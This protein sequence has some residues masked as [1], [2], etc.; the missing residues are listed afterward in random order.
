ML[1]LREWLR[2]LWGTLRP[3]PIDDDL[4]QEIR[5]HLELAEEDARRRG[6][7]PEAA[8]RSARLRVGRPAQAMEQIR[9]QRGLPWLDDLRRD[10][11]HGLRALRHS[12]SFTAIAVMTLALGIGANTAIF[13]IV[14]T[15][16]LRPL[17]YPQPEQLM[18]L[19]TRFP[20]LGFD[21][22]SLSPPEYFEFQELNRSFSAVGA[23]VTAGVNLSADGRAVRVR[24]AFVD[25]PLLR[26]LGVQAAHGRLF[27]PGETQAT[28]S[29]SDSSPRA[30]PRIAILSHDFWQGLLG[31][32]SILGETIEVDGVPHEVLGIMQP[33]AD[34][35]DSGAQVWLP[36][37]LRPANRK[38]RGNHGIYLIGRLEDG[39]SPQAAQTELNA[40][41]ANWG[42]R[43]GLG[44]EK[45]VF[46]LGPAGS[47]DPGALQGHALQMKPLQEEI[48]GS[49]GR[50]VW[51][52]QAAVGL[53][54]LIACAN[55]ASLLL[56]RAE[57]RRRELA[58]RTAIGAS[59]GRLIRQFIAEGLLLSLGGALLGLVV[60][61]AGVLLLLRAYPAALPRMNEIAIDGAALLFTCS[62]AVLTGLLFGLAPLMYTR[63]K[64]LMTGLKE[65]GARGAIGSARQHV[66]RGL[67]VVEIALAVM[68]LTGAGLMVR[69]VYNLTNVDAGFDRTRLMT[70]SLTLPYA[71][72]PDASGRRQLYQR[73]LDSFRAL[74]GVQA[75]TAMSG[76]PP[77][78]SPN[79]TDT[80]IDNYEAP[81]EGPFENVDYYQY[82][83]SDYFETSGIAL[84]Q[85]R[86]FETADAA[87]SGMVAIVNETMARTFWSDE[88]PIGQRLKPCCNMPWFTIIGVAKDVK[89]RGVSQEPGTEV[90]FFVDQTANLDPSIARSPQTINFLLG[91]T[92]PPAALSDTVHR[93]VRQ[94][95]STVPVVR[96]RDMD[97]VFAE[98][99]RRPRLLAQ[100]LG[101]FAGLALL[102]AAIG[103]YGIL[104]YMVAERRREIGIRMALG[105]A[106]SSV[107]A[108]I[109]R[110]GLALTSVG[111]MAGLL[112]ALALSRL[113]G[114]LLFEVQPTDAVTLAA[115]IGTIAVVA[116][117]TCSLPAWRAARLD[118]NTVL[119]ED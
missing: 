23:Y 83:M 48:L 116:A 100:L 73:L 43:A 68:L 52:L 45:H 16:I 51:V 93:I 84:V 27:A 30:V 10:M 6:A 36:L 104:S 88:N 74:P 33:G 53:V 99:I 78:R 13:S 37:G 118:P 72:Y 119:R 87:S 63:V 35:M 101:G 26:A 65:G 15:V 77:E 31:G 14:S 85:G 105:A 61:Q 56:A 12:P 25:E 62:V 91:T 106:R 32:R 95:D 103:A 39:V 117:L 108:Q 110:Q 115:S 29:P 11:K 79:A 22:F 94:A 97:G 47:D 20:S 50:S 58:V 76:L 57:T 69:T 40:L 49:A 66:R 96:L 4:Q 2:R 34:V 60:A 7:S 102:L 98:A 92:L 114:S 55:L 9:D 41:M 54:L 71:D 21:E 24:A 3:N 112:G 107:L 38:N 80:D 46:S 67:V 8:V 17:G 109:L 64:G 59:R 89:Q 113:L 70:F 42:E 90:Y 18:Y 28:N 82:V 19:S 75:A 44:D 81:P 1:A 5:L 111:I 86:G